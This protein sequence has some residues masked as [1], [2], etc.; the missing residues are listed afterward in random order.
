MSKHLSVKNAAAIVIGNAFEWYDYFVYS[1][2]GIY[3]AKLFFPSSNDINS[4]LAVTATFGASFF[5]RPLGGLILGR[6]A[7]K[8]SRVRAM[9][10]S[11]LLMSLALL[12]LSFAPTYHHAGILAP[13]IILTARLMQGFSAGGE[14]GISGIILFESAPSDKRG[15]YCSLHNFGQ[16]I[17]VQLSLIVGIALTQSLS[18][19]QIEQWGWR[20][21][22]IIGL[23]IIPAG[24]YIRRS[25][26]EPALA[27]PNR[28]S[29]LTDT[30]RDN[31]QKILVV[32]GLVGGGTV[33]VYVLLS[34]MP[35]YVNVYLHIDISNAYIATLL[36][37]GLM[38]MFIPVFGWLS[39]KAGRRRLLIIALSS[40]L[41]EIY[42]CFAWLN[43]APSFERLL[44]IQCILCFSMSLYFGA[45]MSAIT[46]IFSYHVRSTCLAL[47]INTSVLIF[48]AFAQFMV[49]L[50]IKL[51]DNPIAVV[52]YPMCGIAISLIATWF[53]QESKEANLGYII[54]AMG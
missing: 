37:T 35:T 10:W 20:I 8:Y 31:L 30:V 7:D 52:I 14:C 44:I 1:F 23:L 4:L 16:M 53:Y 40:C 3:L 45:I 36:G 15:L 22:F 12:M 9:N 48:G 47:S 32:I 49:T 46:E 5:M 24:G 19:A 25:F 51:F 6:I 38:T 2:L 28:N 29:S 11:I 41:I 21:P 17:A 42:P 13:I 34:Y 26:K 27:T 39:D 18:R 54:P 43:A 50:L 33:A